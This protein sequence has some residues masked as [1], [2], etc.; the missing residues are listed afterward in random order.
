MGRVIQSL[1]NVG[2]YNIERLIE[3]TE[4]EKRKL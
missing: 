1:T 4:L 2:T 3:R